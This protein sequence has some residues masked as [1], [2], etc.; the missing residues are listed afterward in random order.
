MTERGEK[1]KKYLAPE[2]EIVNLSEY[3]I[4]TY[5]NPDELPDDEW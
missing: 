2:I 4:V 5:S 1:M 3:D